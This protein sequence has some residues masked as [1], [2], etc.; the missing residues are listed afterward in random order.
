MEDAYQQIK[1]ILVAMI[2]PEFGFFYM[3]VQGV[4]VKAPELNQPCF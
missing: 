2:K 3:Q 1:N 4:T